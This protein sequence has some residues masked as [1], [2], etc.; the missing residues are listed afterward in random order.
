MK[1]IE[2]GQRLTTLRVERQLTQTELADKLNVTPQSIGRWENGIAF[3]D[4]HKLPQI[5][6]ILD[7]TT[8]YLFGR[9]R[10]QQKVFCCNVDEGDGSPA[11][12]GVYR[13]RYETEL[14]DKYLSQG[15]RI[16]NT[17]LSG[18]NGFTYMMVILER[19]D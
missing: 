17:A 3:P 18:A 11:A 7:T 5:A 10:K 9:V 16:V 4:M 15:W 13:R 2:F 19:D 1:F 8:D 14:N 12:D 6:H